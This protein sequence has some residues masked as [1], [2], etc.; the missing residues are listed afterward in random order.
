MSLDGRG[1]YEVFVDVSSH[2]RH[3]EDNE[4]KDSTCY[5]LVDTG[6]P[7]QMIADGLREFASKI[8]ISSDKIKS[9]T[10]IFSVLNKIRAK[11]MGTV[12]NDIIC[13]ILND[14]SEGLNMEWWGYGAE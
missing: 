13:S 5:K 2:K 4:R 12:N 11:S 1:T 9:E 8:A 3:N 6:N 7:D 14:V 10:D